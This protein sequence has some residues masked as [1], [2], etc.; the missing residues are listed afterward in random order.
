M[1]IFHQANKKQLGIFI[2]A[3]YPRLNSLA[4]QLQTLD[5]SSVDFIEIGIPFSDPLA[6]GPVIQKSS[7]VALKNGMNLTLLFDQLAS[8]PQKKPWV[9]MGYLNPVLR[10][11]LEKF[12]DNCDRLEIR[13]VILPDM[14]PELYAHLY[15]ST[16]EKSKVRP[17]FL[18]TPSTSS[19][20]LAFIHGLS[21]ERF[22]YLVSANTT[23]GGK[24]FTLPTNEVIER[25]R[26]NCPDIP[27][28]LGFGIRTA[29]DVRKTHEQMEGAIIG[30]AYL[31][32]IEKGLEKDYL[33]DLVASVYPQ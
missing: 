32:A 10:F 16:F 6:D 21:R 18:V 28:L 8:V 19:N 14:S 7:E 31:Q 5:S 15:K 23:T 27:V 22:L 3:G 20:R 12:L 29:A 11:G 1:N 30:S 13:T 25:I 26:K 2:T 33:K 4:E 9:L 17:V 24:N